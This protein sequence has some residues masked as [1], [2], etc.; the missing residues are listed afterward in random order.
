MG[1]SVGGGAIEI[2]R[3]NGMEVSFGGEY[4]TIITLQADKPG[5]VAGITSVLAVGGVNVAA[6]R[7]FRSG[8]GGDAGRIADGKSAEDAVLTCTQMHG[9][10][11][12]WP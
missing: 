12:I 5:V 10:G 7:L 1:S 11:C 8:R 2:T 3:L 9:T 6:M 4:A